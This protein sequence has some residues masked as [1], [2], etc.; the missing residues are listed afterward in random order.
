LHIYI[1][2]VKIK[3]VH[4]FFELKTKQLLQ[5]S[6][7]LYINKFDKLY[8]IMK[9]NKLLWVF[10]SLLAVGGLVFIGNKLYKK[11]RTTSGNPDKDNR[12]ILI[13]RK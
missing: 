5:R 12:K 2:R 10:V 8:F 9:K 7:F 13:I 11:S 3:N 4:Y 6:I 1:N